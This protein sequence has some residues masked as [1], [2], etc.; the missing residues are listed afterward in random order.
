VRDSPDTSRESFGRKATDE[1]AI[2]PLLQM[3]NTS[4]R[5]LEP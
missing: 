4:G 5:V 1:A 2:D 3:P